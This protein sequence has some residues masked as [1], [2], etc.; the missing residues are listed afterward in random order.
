[1]KAWD[2]ID[3][4]GWVDLLPEFFVINWINFTIDGSSVNLFDIILKKNQKA[5]W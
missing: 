1:M 2:S 3:V 4:F 5:H